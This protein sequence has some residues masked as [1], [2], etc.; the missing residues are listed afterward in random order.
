VTGPPRKRLRSQRVH[1]QGGGGIVTGTA[2]LSWGPAFGGVDGDEWGCGCSLLPGIDIGLDHTK[3]CAVHLDGDLDFNFVNPAWTLGGRVSEDAAV[4][5]DVVR[6]LGGHTSF[7]DLDQTWTLPWSAGGQV[8][9]DEDVNYNPLTLGAH[10][11]H[12]LIDADYGTVRTCGAHATLELVDLD[13]GDTYRLGGHTVM[14]ALAMDNTET[15]GSHLSA[16]ADGA[17]FWQSE[18][19]TVGATGTTL[20]VNKPTGTVDGDLLLAFIALTGTAS[21]PDVSSVPTDWALIRHTSQ[22]DGAGIDRVRSYWKLASGEG[23]SYNWG[24]SAAADANLGEIHC[25]RGVHQTTPINIDNG[26]GQNVI[27]PIN[28]TVTTTSVNCLVF[29]FLWHDHLLGTAPTNGTHAPPAGHDE[30]GEQIDT[31]TAAANYRSHTM[32]K[33]FAAAASTGTVTHDCTNTVTATNAICQ[34][35]A[36]APGT[37]TLAA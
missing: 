19:H 1:I 5:Y 2:N 10:V 24:F 7:T 11:N 29:A 25:I 32:T 17:P 12:D 16:T 4:D 18:A 14:D 26:N 30:H 13:Y 15:L 20:T 33:V 34:R 21:T 31:H 9:F 6:T 3:G 36:V 8:S 37:I 28:P 35:V 22:A 27:D 23:A